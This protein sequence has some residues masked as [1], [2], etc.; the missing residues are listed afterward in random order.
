MTTELQRDRLGP[1]DAGIA[2][3]NPGSVLMPGHEVWAKA[4]AWH[5]SSATPRLRMQRPA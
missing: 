5:L 1:A 4:L 3:M 2:G